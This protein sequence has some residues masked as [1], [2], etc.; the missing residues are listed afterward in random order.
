MFNTTARRGQMK[1]GATF[2]PLMWVGLAVVIVVLASVLAFP[3]AR[4][5][6]Q[7]LVWLGAGL[8]GAAMVA[9]HLSTFLKNLRELQDKPPPPEPAAPPTPPS[10][11]GIHVNLTTGTAGPGAAVTGV[12][13]GAMTIGQVGQLTLQPP[14]EPAAPPSPRV[15]LQ[16]PPQDFT[17]RQAELEQLLAAFD[18]ASAALISGVTGGAGIGKT[19]LARC[20]AQSLAERFPDARLEIDLKGAVRPPERPL[21]PEQAMRRLLAPFYP[22]VPLPDDPQELRGRYQDTFRRHTCLLLLDNAADAAQVRPLL[23]PPPSAA[24]VTS[25]LNFQLPEAGLRPLRLELLEMPAALQLLGQVSPRLQ[26]APRARLEAI[27]AACGRLPLALRIAAAILES[28]PDWS[29]DELLARLADERTRLATLRH[30]NDPDLDVVAWLELSYRS[31]DDGLAERFRALGV[32]PAPFDRRALAAVWEGEEAAK[33]SG[34]AEQALGAL[35]AVWE[36]EGAAK[37]SGAAE[38]ALGALLGRNLVDYRPAS[39]DYALH[40]LT[41][42]Y[43]QELLLAQPEQARSAL[44]RH[45][46]HYL[47]RGAAAEALF[48]QGGEGVLA[49]LAA[50]DGIWPHLEAAWRRLADP[51][52]GWP[53]LEQAERWLNDFPGRMAYVLDLRLPPREKLPYL[54]RAAAAARALGDRSGEGVHLGNLGSAYFS[55]GEPQ[56]AIEFYQQALAIDREIGDRR[57]EGNRLG[58]LGLAYAALGEPRRAIEFYQQALAIA[59]EIGDRRGEGNHLGNL[60]SAYAALGEPRRAIEFHEQALAIDREIGDRRGEGADLGNLGNAYAALGEPRRAIEFYQQALAIDRGIGDRRGEGADLGNLGLAYAALGEPRRAIEFYQ[61]ALAIAQEIGDRR[62]EGNRLGNLGLA[63]AALGEPQRAIE[64]YQQAL[65]IARQIGDRR[66]EVNNLTNLG[67]AFDA[68]GEHQQAIECFDQTIQ[69]EPEV[70]RHYR[71]R[72]ESWIKLGDLD[73]AEADCSRAESLAPDHPFTH[74]RRG[75]L[76]YARGEHSAAIERYR[77]AASLN[78]GDATEFNFDLGLPLLCT[79][80]ADEALA[81]IRERLAAHPRPSD[82]DSMLA[83]YE[84]LAQR[85]PNL[86]GLS[87]ALGLLRQAASS[88]PEDE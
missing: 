57:G 77:K 60:G 33:L 79:G 56:R 74:A 22:G 20:L 73:R 53:A 29:A 63:Y 8:A 88:P 14:G 26:G 16:D 48:L 12:E 43:A 87:E 32:F 11:P 66:M 61:Q 39:G 47:E 49:G 35:A 45:A 27:A 71:N 19:A 28:R 17:G 4:T 24:I 2:K 25:R 58:N 67:A 52:G 68:L 80:Q 7:V 37:L 5:F 1:K 72:A 69:L 38:Q 9:S 21:T 82:L 83:E 84:S 31:L 75:Q 51:H 78:S 41:R 46:A 13:I 3:Q 65:A 36:G 70:A 10:G 50:F 15:T 23:P 64:F 34:A 62:G 42:L 81:L 44:A 86:P 54:E 6:P 55:L 85:Q 59:R 18:A 30:P 40:D 76:H